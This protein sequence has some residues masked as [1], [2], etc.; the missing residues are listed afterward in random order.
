MDSN[1]IVSLISALASLGASAITI[2]GSYKLLNYRMGELEKKVDKH[3]S[4]LDEIKASMQEIPLI[5][6]EFE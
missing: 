6:N 1:V 4:L 5:K 2:F 3:N